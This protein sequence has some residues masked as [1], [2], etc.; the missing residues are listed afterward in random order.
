MDLFMI[1]RLM[2]LL[3]IVILSN[4]L[5]DY[6]NIIPYSFKSYRY[7]KL[8]NPT[9]DIRRNL[10]RHVVH[11]NISSSHAYYKII[12]VDNEQCDLDVT[13]GNIV[14]SECDRF[15]KEKNKHRTCAG[16]GTFLKQS[17]F[18]FINRTCV[19]VGRWLKL[20]ENIYG[21]CTYSDS[22]IFI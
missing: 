6:G 10:L 7:D 2:T 20:T 22:Y 17:N 18:I 15:T 4:V 16:M 1:I 12:Q 5:C 21:N 14:C 11:S 19:T 13:H 8:Y 9:L 3:L